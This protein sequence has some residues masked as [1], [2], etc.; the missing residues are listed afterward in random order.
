MDKKTADKIVHYVN[1]R[2]FY[3]ALI[4]FV[5]ERKINPECKI[6]PYIGEC[7]YKICSRIVYLPNFIN[8]AFRDDMVG[9]AIE[10]CIRYVDRFKPEKSKNPFA[11]Y[12]SIAYYAC[13]RRIQLEKKQVE[14]RAKFV[15]SGSLYRET[16]DT[17]DKEEPEYFDPVSMS[18]LA[19]LYE[20]KIPEV[21]KVKKEKPKTEHSLEEFV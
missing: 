5:A 15:Q 9:D 14:T 1:N 18:N 2:E 11:Y 7:V 3:E 6:P 20:Y 13:V 4:P 8:Y 16:V 17:M 19:Y 12:S 21:K 10:N